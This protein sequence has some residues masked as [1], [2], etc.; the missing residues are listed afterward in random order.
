MRILGQVPH[1]SNASDSVAKQTPTPPPSG[2]STK[3]LPDATA[4]S[5]QFPSDEEVP[6]TTLGTDGPPTPG[7]ILFGKYEVIREL[8]GGGMGKVLL[9][10]NH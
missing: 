1:A 4:L 7:R 5:Q 9:V 6:E 2:I 3:P 8:G 10:R